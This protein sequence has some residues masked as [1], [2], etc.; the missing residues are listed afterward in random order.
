MGR[1][2]LIKVHYLLSLWSIVVID[3]LWNHRNSIENSDSNRMN[4]EKGK[5]QRTN[6]RTNMLYSIMIC[7]FSVEPDA[8]A[9]KWKPSPNFPWENLIDKSWKSSCIFVPLNG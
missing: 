1:N 3:A 2:E 7:G 8:N 4:W 6:Q 9:P 5:K